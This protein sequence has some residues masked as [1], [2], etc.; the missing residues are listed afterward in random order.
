MALG[1]LSKTTEIEMPSKFYFASGSGN[2]S[3][4]DNKRD[5]DCEESVFANLDDIDS[6]VEDKG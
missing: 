6:D 5:Q 3:T 2:S 4:C 1:I